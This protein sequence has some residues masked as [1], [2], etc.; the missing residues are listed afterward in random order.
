MFEVASGKGCNKVRNLGVLQNELMKELKGKKFLLVLDDFWKT[1][2]T[3]A[4]YAT[5]SL[6][7]WG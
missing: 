7:S 1:D 3:N 2:V 4:R 6:D 5:C